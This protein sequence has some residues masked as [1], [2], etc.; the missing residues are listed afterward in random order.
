MT[1][2][3]CST[4]ALFLHQR[5]LSSLFTL[6]FCIHSTPLSY[7][8]ST[9]SSLFI[10]SPYSPHLTHHSS[11]FPSHSSLLTLFSS[12]LST[13]IFPPSSLIFPVYSLLPIFSPHSSL[14]T[15]ISTPSSHLTP[16][17]FH[18]F[19]S[20]SHLTSHYSLLPL[21]LFTPSHTYPT[22]LFNAL[23]SPHFL[24]LSCHS[25]LTSL[26]FHFTPLDPA[27]TSHLTPLFLSPPLFSDLSPSH[28]SCLTSLSVFLS[29]HFS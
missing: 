2:H 28:L 19:P 21:S 15:L 5:L 29:L 16:S 6:F 23:L 18:P 1:C 26:M 24:H 22:S 13:L 25:D 3:Q 9:H 8:S 14:V 11:L 10:V 7:L 12:L 20:P 17:S 4:C 27:F